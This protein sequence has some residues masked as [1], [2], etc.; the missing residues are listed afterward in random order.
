M[1]KKGGQ[2]VSIS[3]IENEFINIPYIDEVSIIPLEDEFWGNKI[4]LFYVPKTKI[5]G[6]QVKLIEH[7]KNLL[8]T[9]EQPDEYIE[10]DELPKTSI[11][12][13]IK[14][15]LIKFYKEGK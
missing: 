4:L 14:K 2:F 12:K 3:A 10:F 11:G 5:D 7:A 1:I 6:I 8:N 13:I 15:D 9:I